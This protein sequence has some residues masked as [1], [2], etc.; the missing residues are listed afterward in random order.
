M[1]YIFSCEKEWTVSPD[2]TKVMYGDKVIADVYGTDEEAYSEETQCANAR[3]MAAAQQLYRDM[4][5]LCFICG[6]SKSGNP[7]ALSL[8]DLGDKVIH[9]SEY[10]REFLRSIQATLVDQR[11]SQC[12]GCKSPEEL[13]DMRD[14]IN[15]LSNYIKHD[16][17]TEKNS[18]EL[19]NAVSEYTR[20]FVCPYCASHD[21]EVHQDVGWWICCNDC[22]LKT[23]EME[24]LNKVLNTWEALVSMYSSNPN[25][26]RDVKNG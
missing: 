4:A 20:G 11:Y 23:P 3:L 14:K 26:K 6:I 9:D 10:Y 1:S 24:D 2:G 21:V 17:D 12:F 7:H 25:L 19:S 8:S 13:R 18:A 16:I 15:D 22:D 5:Y